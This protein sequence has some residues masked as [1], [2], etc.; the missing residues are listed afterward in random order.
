MENVYYIR[1]QKREKEQW[2]LTAMEA[3]WKVKQS[4]Q[5]Q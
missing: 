3:V 4:V 1:G 5:R 2:D